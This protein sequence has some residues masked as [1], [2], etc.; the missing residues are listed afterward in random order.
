MI[1]LEG[2]EN[3]DYVFKTTIIV[4]VSGIFQMQYIDDKFKT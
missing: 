2:K 4:E 1:D 3:L